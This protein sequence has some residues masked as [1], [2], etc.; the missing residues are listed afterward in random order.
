[1]AFVIVML[2]W[3]SRA[4]WTAIWFSTGA[5]PA[6]T[7]SLHRTVSEIRQGKS[8][9]SGS[10]DAK[11]MMTSTK[12]RMVQRS[13]RCI[14]ERSLP[15]RLVRWRMAAPRGL[16][17]R[18][19]AGPGTQPRRHAGNEGKEV[20]ARLVSASG[21]RRRIKSARP[22]GEEPAPDAERAGTKKEISLDV[23]IAVAGHMFRRRHDGTQTV[24]DTS[25]EILKTHVASSSGSKAVIEWPSGDAD[26]RS[27]MITRMPARL[28]SPTGRRPRTPSMGGRKACV[29]ACRGQSGSLTGARPPIFSQIVNT[30]GRTLA[31]HSKRA[32]NRPM[33]AFNARKSITRFLVHRAALRVRAASLAARRFPDS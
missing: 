8:A 33:R 9:D 19:N 14:E 3:P 27:T 32:A 28:R 26:S 24:A 6:P 10:G 21:I 22:N 29:S 4:S 20:R 30:R 16:D 11:R 5:A 7:F 15:A 23:Q 1:M 18:I 12:V 17:E 31:A 13:F 25:R 2:S